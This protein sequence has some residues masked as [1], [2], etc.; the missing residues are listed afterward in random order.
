MRL[1]RLT[2]IVW[3]TAIIAAAIILTAVLS[4]A[5]LSAATGGDAQGSAE[6]GAQAP[7]APRFLSMTGLYS[8]A[9]G[10]K[11]DSRNRMFSPQ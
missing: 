7:V 9:A 11:I 2:N 1:T 3:T 10:L 5:T 8:N 4:T 6:T